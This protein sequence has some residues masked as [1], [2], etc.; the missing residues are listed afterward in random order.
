[1]KTLRETIDQLDEIS[2]RD[3]L[4]GAG[5]AAIAGAAGGS[6]AQVGGG[7]N[8]SQ[9]AANKAAGVWAQYAKDNKTVTKWIS[10]TIQR[11]AMQFYQLGGNKDFQGGANSALQDAVNAV[12]Q[13]FQGLYRVI[14]KD[15]EEGSIAKA[16]LKGY[17][18]PEMSREEQ[19]KIMGSM[20]R[21]NLAPTAEKF[22]QAY[23]DS[24]N[25][26]L[27]S[28][29]QQTTAPAAQP[30]IDKKTEHTT[31]K[32]AVELYI[33]SKIDP[34]F[35]RFGPE[36]KVEIE[37]LIKKYNAKELINQMYQNLLPKWTSSKTSDPEKY[38]KFM[39]FYKSNSDRILSDIRKLN[40]SDEE[41]KES[42]EQVEE[43]SPDALAKINELTK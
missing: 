34:D 33:L 37:K 24:L 25:R 35:S 7:E 11:R 18:S 14:E 1:M 40:G 27:Q 43:A 9:W 16:W 20:N 29:Q 32:F 26:T 6:K 22:V 13:S 5:A 31:V 2:R 36:L 15:K 4:K 3:V 21:V 19:W 42:T 28:T 39:P 38:Q 10:E 12:D 23:T 41:F 8:E 30:E 17:I